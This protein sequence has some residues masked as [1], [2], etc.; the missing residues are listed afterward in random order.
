MNILLGM[1]RGSSL[2]GASCQCGM[3]NARAGRNVNESVR[4][5]ANQNGGDVLNCYNSTINVGLSEE[6]L[7]IKEW[8]SPLE[9]NTKHHY[10]RNRRL[11][12][13]GD[14]VLQKDEFE[15]WRKS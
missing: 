6:D 1:N 9:S 12:G 14:W 4:G 3:S 7:R 5:R 10:V 2:T 15:L 11:D 13:V 8:L